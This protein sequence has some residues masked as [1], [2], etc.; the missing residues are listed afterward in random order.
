MNQASP[1]QLEQHA[2]AVRA[3]TNIFGKRLTNAKTK[4]E[5]LAD[6]IDALQFQENDTK[7]NLKSILDQISDIQ[8]ST[9]LP[10]KEWSD[11]TNAKEFFS[12]I[13]FNLKNTENPH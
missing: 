2:T 10:S 8:D 11:L 5:D 13:Y 12:E 3:I 4:I 1:A 9:N 7:E 6:K